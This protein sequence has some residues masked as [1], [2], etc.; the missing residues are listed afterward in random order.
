LRLRNLLRDSPE[1][2]RRLRARYRTLLI[3]EFQDTDPLQTDIALAFARNPDNDAIEHGRVFL[4]GDP[5][6][7]IYRF[8]RADMAVYSET[9]V[10]LEAARSGM[11][12]LAQNRRSRDVVLDFVNSVFQRVIG[13]GE[14]P[15]LQPP[16]RPVHPE[17]TVV[18]RGPDVGYIGGVVDAPAREARR[19]EAA[20]VAA[21][22]RAALEQGWQV[23]DRSEN[24]IRPARYR[25]IAI[26]VPTRAI[27]QPL[28]RALGAAGVPYRV[29]GGSLVYATQEVRDRS[30]ASPRSTTRRTKSPSWVLRS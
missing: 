30:T 15:S 11:P 26:L 4:V 27:L 3:D 29:E 5:K 6:Q 10:T 16:Y 9:R 1:A 7:S 14:E 18:L 8:R 19:I 23:E 13:G 24:R 21:W 22:C 28:E 12:Q 2:R 25:D 17:R 20:Q